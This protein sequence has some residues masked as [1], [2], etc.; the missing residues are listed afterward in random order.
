MCSSCQ[1]VAYC[2]PA[3]QRTHWK[4]HKVACREAANGY[5]RHI[6]SRA[7]AGHAESLFDVGV[8]YSTGRGGVVKDAAQAMVWFHRASEAGVVD[9]QY[10]L[11]LCYFH[12]DGL[13]R[14]QR[15]L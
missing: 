11:G 15:R 1:R 13:P 4:A 8:H 9:A 6:L 10:T 14:M 7:E 12:G 3:C 5:F 2:G